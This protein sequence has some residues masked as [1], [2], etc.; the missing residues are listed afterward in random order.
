TP[1]ALSDDTGWT[2][3]DMTNPSTPLSGNGSYNDASGHTCAIRDGDLYCWG[4]ND[5]GQ[6]GLGDTAVHAT[7]T[8]VTALTT[9]WQ[10]VAVGTFSTCAIT[11]GGSLYCWG[12]NQSGEL[13]QGDSV[14]RTSPTQV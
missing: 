2:T 11:S 10:R 14:Q 7:P 12:R 6:L 8:Q 5:F 13:G 4:A 3:L 9:T 1:T